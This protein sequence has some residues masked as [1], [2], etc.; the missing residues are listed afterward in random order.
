M[1]PCS[2]SNTFGHKVM[3]YSTHTR[4]YVIILELKTAKPATEQRTEPQLHGGLSRKGGIH[5][6]NAFK[7]RLK[8]Y[9]PRANNK[10]SGT[11]ECYPAVIAK[12]LPQAHPY[13]FAS[14]THVSLP[15]LCLFFSPSRVFCASN[16]PYPPSL[17][18]C[19]MNQFPTY[20]SPSS[21]SHPSVLV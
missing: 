16:S 11:F 15:T 10:K 20:I 18:L 2:L 6:S 12:F 5:T 7:C 8:Q 9:N 13:V 3:R 19:P 1:L 21:L 4:L 17:L 14:A